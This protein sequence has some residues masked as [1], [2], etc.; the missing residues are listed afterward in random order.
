MRPQDIAK[1][2]AKLEAANAGDDKSLEELR[3][4]LKAAK[5]DINS[6]TK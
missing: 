2:I 3:E 6:Y 1:K 5:A 4:K